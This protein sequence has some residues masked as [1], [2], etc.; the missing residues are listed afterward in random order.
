[1]NS[2]GK[3]PN[4]DAP[5]SD[6]LEISLFGPG[7]GESVAVHLGGGRWMIVDACIDSKTGTPAVIDYLEQIGV[8]YTENVAVVLATHWDDDHVRG[9]GEVVE[10]CTKARFA[11]S[12]AFRSIDFLT[13]VE[14]GDLGTRRLSSGPREFAM[15]LSA[16]KARK[17]A[18]DDLGGAPRIITE[19]T[20]VDR[21]QHCEV[22]ALSPSSAAVQAGQKA[23]ASLLP[24]HLQPRLRLI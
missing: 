7:Y 22:R 2:G 15:V 16:L 4:L 14:L 20:I 23:I 3:T 9:L 17:A 21:S 11:F 6:E 10:R 12:S 24:K 5:G 13:L 1:V 18:G 8:N 19:N